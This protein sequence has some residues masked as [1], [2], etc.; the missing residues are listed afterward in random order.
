MKRTIDNYFDPE[1]YQ[2]IDLLTGE[3]VDVKIF[4]EKASQSG[5]EKAYAKTIAEYIE[6]GGG[7][8]ERFLAYL[9]RFKDSKNMIYGTTKEMA[10]NSSSSD[11]VIK[12]V[13]RRLKERGMIRKMRN[14]AYMITPKMIRNG[15]KERG[16]MLLRIWDQ[17]N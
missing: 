15:S 1:T 5:W 9:I 8:S 6:C 7:S 12:R 13:I 16:A 2:V 17:N 11:A 3:P 4:I 14:G 10:I